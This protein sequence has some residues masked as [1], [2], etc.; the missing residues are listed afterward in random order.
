MDGEVDEEGRQG[1]GREG[2]VKKGAIGRVEELNW[3]ND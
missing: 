1:K 3:L 2:R